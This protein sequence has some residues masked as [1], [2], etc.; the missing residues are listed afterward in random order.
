MR[1]IMIR[2]ILRNSFEK[3][4]NFVRV[5]REGVDLY[6]DPP[7]PSFRKVANL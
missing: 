3:G 7:G 1:T 4:V 6:E 2:G 5:I